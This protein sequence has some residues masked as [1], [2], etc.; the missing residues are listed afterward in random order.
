VSL[1]G[2]PMTPGTDNLYI[3]IICNSKNLIRYIP[4]QVEIAR[5]FIFALN[6]RMIP[7]FLKIPVPCKDHS[8]FVMHR[9]SC[10][11]STG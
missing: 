3:P 6:F 2:F 10:W 1:V 7:E 9:N 4:T 8:K 11:L 5:F